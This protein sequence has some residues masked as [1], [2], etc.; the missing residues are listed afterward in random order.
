MLIADV[1]YRYRSIR[2]PE[3]I[4]TCLLVGGLGRS[5]DSGGVATV[6]LRRSPGVLLVEVTVGWGEG[7]VD[8]ASVDGGTI[9]TG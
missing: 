8:L 2:D 7:G 6:V 1:L 3:V 4:L 5:W 9:S